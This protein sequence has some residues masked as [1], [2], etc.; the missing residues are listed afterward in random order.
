M[1]RVS[2]RVFQAKKDLELC[3]RVLACLKPIEAG[4]AGLPRTQEAVKKEA[5]Y[6]QMRAESD[7]GIIAVETIGEW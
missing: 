6:W 2:E 7:K 4:L 1:H 5:A 3:D